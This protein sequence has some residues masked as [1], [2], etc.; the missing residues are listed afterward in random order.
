[1]IYGLLIHACLIGQPDRCQ[2]VEVPVAGCELPMPL[3]GAAVEWLRANP[4]WQMRKI[5]GCKPGRGA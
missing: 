2:W 3:F 5:V 1:M 4:L